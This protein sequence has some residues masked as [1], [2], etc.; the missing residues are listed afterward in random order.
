MIPRKP[1]PRRDFFRSASAAV[2][3]T[4]GSTAWG[5]EKT[6]PGYLAGHEMLYAEDPR[7]AALKWFAGARF[8]LSIEPR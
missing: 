1:I 6:P 8:G 7:A 2:A 4:V 5:R 3:A